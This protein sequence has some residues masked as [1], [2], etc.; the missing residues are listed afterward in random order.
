MTRHE[1]LARHGATLIG[2]SA[3]TPA[4]QAEFAQREH[5][6]YPLL[7]DH[8]LKLAE[9]MGLPTFETSGL[10]LYKRLTF[11]AEQGRIVKV[12]YPVF[13]PDRNA[14]EVLAWLESLQSDC[15]TVRRWAHARIPHRSLRTRSKAL[16]AFAAQAAAAAGTPWPTPSRAPAGS[17]EHF[18]FVF[19]DTDAY[20]IV[21]LPDA[22]A[23]AA[24]ALTV[25]SAGGATTKTV[26][27]AD[28]RGGRRRGQALGRVPAA[29]QLAQRPH[30]EF[31]DTVNDMVDDVMYARRDAAAPG[32][33]TRTASPP[34]APSTASTPRASASCATACCAR[35]TR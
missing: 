22:E 17:L 30:G 15:T 28:T 10:R 18:Y 12:F 26:P 4:E 21:D 2:I 7:S 33:A 14:D 32:T 34:S 1:E 5:I 11:I 9:A 31:I 35:P 3:Q 16:R 23:A 24:V 8:E 13:P 20:V 25:N 6:P 29:W 27:L 19:G